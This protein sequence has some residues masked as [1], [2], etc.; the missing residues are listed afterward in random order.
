MIR[1]DDCKTV[2]T[3]TLRRL[4]DIKCECTVLDTDAYGDYIKYTYK[5]E[6]R[7]VLCHDMEKMLGTRVTISGSFDYSGYTLI[8]EE[9]GHRYHFI[10]FEDVTQ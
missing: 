7:S 4:K 3:L 6:L 10:L 8:D 5:G 2:M 9:K 1:V